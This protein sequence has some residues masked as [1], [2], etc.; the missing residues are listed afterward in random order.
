MSYET[1][2]NFINST[3]TKSAPKGKPKLDTHE[4]ETGKKI[5]D[6]QMLTL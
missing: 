5:T 2:I 4:Y 6:A 1:I 3:I